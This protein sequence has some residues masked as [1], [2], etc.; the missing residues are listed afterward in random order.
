MQTCLFESKRQRLSSRDLFY[1]FDSVKGD[2]YDKEVVSYNGA[3]DGCFV[4]SSRLHE[5]YKQ[6]GDESIVDARRVA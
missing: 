4:I 6:H 1:L 5:Q 2:L 3:D